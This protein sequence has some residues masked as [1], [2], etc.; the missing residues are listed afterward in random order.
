MGMQCVRGKKGPT[1]EPDLNPIL[2]ALS[3]EK[4]LLPYQPSWTTN[5]VKF[6]V[7]LR[8]SS[9]FLT[10]IQCDALKQ[11]DFCQ[12]K[13]GSFFFSGIMDRM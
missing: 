10:L 12:I 2:C 3:Q 6:C 7:M 8:L 1:P 5:H 4:M 13:G 9:G 11:M